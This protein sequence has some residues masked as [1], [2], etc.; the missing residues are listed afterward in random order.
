M[1]NTLKVM[2]VDDNPDDRALTIRELKREFPDLEVKEIINSNDF[3]EAIEDGD[4]DLVITDYSIKWTDGLSVLEK[5]KKLYPECPVIMFTGTGSEDI[6]VRAMK[7]GLDDYVIK[8]T[9]HFVRLPASVRSVLRSK[10][11]REARQKAEELY[12][13]L[14][15]KVPI[16]LYS[17]KP[18]GQIVA[19][20]S[21]MVD[22]LKY[23]DKRT[24][25]DIDTSI[26]STKKSD[27]K[28]M[29][30]RLENEGVIR[31]YEHKLK[32]Y[33]DEYIWVIESATAI[34]DENGDIAYIEGSMLDISKRKKAQH[35][36]EENKRKIELLHNTA[37]D[38][39]GCSNEE[40]V[41]DS[42]IKAAKD[43]LDF[44]SSSIIIHEKGDL[45]VKKST[46]ADLEVDS[47]IPSGRGLCSKTYEENKTFL[48]NDLKEYPEAK[49]FSSDYR[50][51]I[52]API[53]DIGVI[54]I[55]SNELNYFDEYD[56]DLVNIL[57]MHTHDALVRIRSKKELEM[58]EALHR[59]IIEN[60]GTAMAIIEEDMTA[61][62]VN[63]RMEELTGYT[64]EDMQSTIRWTEF[65]VDE[66][67]DK[68]KEFHRIRR[69]KPENIP[70][71]YTFRMVTRYGDIRDILINVSM[72]P[73]TKKSIVSLTDITQNIK[74]L[75]AFEESQEMFRIAFENSSHGM[76]ILDLDGC[77]MEV[78]E[79]LCEQLK[80]AERDIIDKYLY[81]LIEDRDR[82]HCKEKV[83][84]MA[85]G[86]SK[87]CRRKTAFTAMDG[88]KFNGHLNVSAI[89]D[90]DGKTINMLAFVEKVDDHR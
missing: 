55:I 64:K 57:C 74:T 34:C 90:S 49:P 63:S 17:V 83:R 86:E 41:Y 44:N 7:G 30:K 59:S 69:E 73:G 43:I 70:V 6:V 24:L 33:T 87:R 54:Q 56:K 20:N 40:E 82:E 65:V 3:R 22:M 72:I 39:A 35:E 77:I 23:P 89:S 80:S 60:T 26:C 13:R 51:A 10:E 19:V 25:M 85:K 68:M 37:N 88:S 21:A 1:K 48:V 42:V 75:K 45:L 31:D 27:R 16:G 32:T 2:I 11:D 78:N 84:E 29:I 47:K 5:V 62:M 46:N 14:F 28:D 58:S 53:G 66:D 8:T 4:F 71:V 76:A 52:S 18:G 50:S 79:E 61:S 15:E 12:E 38:L 9:S 36:L 81:D 67:L